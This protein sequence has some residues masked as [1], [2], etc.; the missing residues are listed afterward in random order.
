MDTR[1]DRGITPETAD[2]GALERSSESLV[3]ERQETLRRAMYIVT[4]VY[5][6]NQ[7]SST[8]VIEAEVGDLLIYGETVSSNELIAAELDNT[9][10]RVEHWTNEA[11]NAAMAAID[12]DPV[13]KNPN[14]TKQYPTSQ[15]MINGLFELAA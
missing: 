5:Y 8:K 11:K 15:S 13:A 4:A 3:V 9:V 2:N 14:K 10:D 7:N 6:D 12:Y 1:L